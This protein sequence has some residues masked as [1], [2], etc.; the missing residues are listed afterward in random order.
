MQTKLYSDLL[1]D[2]SYFVKVTIFK[3]DKEN[4]KKIVS[5]FII[6]IISNQFLINNFYLCR[7]F[8]NKQMESTDIVAK[9]NKV[10]RKVFKDESIV[11]NNE[12]T[13]SEVEKWDSLTHIIL[14]SSTEEEF[15]IKFKL[16]ELIAMKNVGDFLKS[17]EEKVNIKA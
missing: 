16:K 3:F 7:H 10:F 5:K 12:M 2:L 17:I 6:K 4:F 1:A 11:I 14:I 8:K 9:L 13:A 15:G